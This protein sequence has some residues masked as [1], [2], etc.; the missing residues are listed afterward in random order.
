MPIERLK[1]YMLMAGLMWWEPKGNFPYGINVCEGLD[2]KRSL[3]LHLWY[4]SASVSPVGEVARD[5]CKAFQV[6]RKWDVGQGLDGGGGGGGGR[7]IGM[8]WEREV[9]W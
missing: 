9:G 8:W 5:F 4:V 6:R 1:L 3:A 2:W 7:F